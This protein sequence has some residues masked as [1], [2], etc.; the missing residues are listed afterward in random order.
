IHRRVEMLLDEKV[1][2]CAA[3]QERAEAITFAHAAGMLLEQLADRRAHRQ[4]PETGAVYLAARSV[5]LRARVGREPERSEPLRAVVDDVRNVAE[6][7][8]V[9][10][11]RRL[12]PQPD[13]LRKR[14][15]RARN[16]AAAFERADQRGFLAADVAA[17]ARVQVQRKAELAA[18][19]VLAEIAAL[20]G[21]CDRAP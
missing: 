16:R 18:E 9:V 12:A 5:E 8:D 7:L 17:R 13:E 20:G 21:L 3:G 2:R 10:H 1:R 15:L 14:R 19:N 4:L 11:D 6:C